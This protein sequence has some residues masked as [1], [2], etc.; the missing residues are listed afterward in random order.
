M[1]AT[2]NA[3]TAPGLKRDVLLNAVFSFLFVAL[4]FFTPQSVLKSV[5]YILFYKPNFQF[6]VDTIR[7]GRVPL[8]NPYIGLGRPF[9]ADVQN[10]VFYPPVYLI[11]LGQGT[12]VFLLLSLHVLLATLGMQ[13][14]GNALG[15]AKR[16]GH[17]IALSF[18]ASL[19]LTSRI[20]AGQFLYA[21]ALCYVP[22]LFCLATRIG[23]EWNR[24]WISSYAVMLALQFFCGHPQVFWFSTLSQ[25]VF[26]LARAVQF[27]LRSSARDAFRGV[28]QFGVA[29]AFCFGLV[30]LVLL[31]F[32]EL[33]GQGNR[34]L[35]SLDYVNFGRLEWLDFFS[36]FTDPPYEQ[37][38]DW[39]KNLFVG[40]VVLVSGL[41]GL[42]SV[43]DRNVRGMLAVALLALLLGLG[44][45]SPLFRSFYEYI[46]GYSAFRVH[47]RSSF[48]IVFALLTA[49]GLWLG[50]RETTRRD[51]IVPA[52]I[53]GV[54]LLVTLICF[55]HQTPKWPLGLWMVGVAA[56]LLCF[57]PRTRRHGCDPR[58][59]RVIV[60]ALVVV[61]VVD[62]ANANLQ[63][64]IAYTFLNVQKTTPEFP[65]QRALVSAL[66]ENRLRDP[67]RPPPRVLVSR[68][69]VPAN[70]GMIYHYSSVDAYTS[71]FLRRPWDYVHKI[72][73]LTEPKMKNTSLSEDLFK[74]GSFA[75]PELAIDMELE[76][77]ARTF[78]INPRPSSRVFLV[79]RAFVSD[80]Y[81]DAMDQLTKHQDIR[82]EAVLE[83]QPTLS[84]GGH[85]EEATASVEI[86]KSTPDAIH[87]HVETSNNALLVLA[88]AWYPGWKAQ[89]DDATCSSI[90]ANIWMRAFPVPAGKHEVRIFYNQNWL[91]IG[92]LIS[93]S[94]LA[95]LILW[96][97][98]VPR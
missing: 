49:A 64:K 35:N 52:S 8:W 73:G 17:L 77:V 96:V 27:P 71:L 29:V 14:F 59:S 85:G 92:V 61:Q 44:D 62:L 25:G 68:M 86:W 93:V 38:V 87:L 69:L 16:P 12:G 46:P 43:A 97:R 90:P 76:P 55:R 89:I 28:L 34:S 72:F 10:A 54:I 24:K 98:G 36:L 66:D 47:C 32:L 95:M 22:I 57:L 79:H 5:D 45:Q 26:V 63:S 21:C 37:L 15:M 7:D 65:Y 83:E 82:Q 48:L 58:L 75:Y 42:S 4:L 84:L 91:R 13:A 39:E 20:M 80:S 60:G 9:L 30:A 3:M 88:E 11:M 1:G 19:S 41:A 31:P 70:F 53:A 94:S 51:R 78:L 33:A 2:L 50:R 74:R 81:G 23:R 56:T 67:L 18:A 6:L 40:S